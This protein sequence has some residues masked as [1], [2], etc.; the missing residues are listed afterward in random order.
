MPN[1]EGAFDVAW[2][3]AMIVIKSRQAE[4]YFPLSRSDG[5]D[6]TRFSPNNVS[7]MFSLTY[8]LTSTSPRFQ[9]AAGPTQQLNNMVERSHGDLPRNWGPSPE[10]RIKFYTK[11]KGDK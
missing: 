8:D 5:S 10:R 9:I 6:V 7:R 11:C 4:R 3:W 1:V 2:L